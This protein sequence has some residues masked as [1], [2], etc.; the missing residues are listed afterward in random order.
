MLE[1]SALRNR[2][3]TTY[4]LI[5][6]VS[7]V[8]K[9]LPESHHVYRCKDKHA[10]NDKGSQILDLNIFIINDA[11]FRVIVHIPV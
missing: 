10:Q 2:R 11:P 1:E 8:L 5:C 7:F 9:S 4:S 3:E 6:P